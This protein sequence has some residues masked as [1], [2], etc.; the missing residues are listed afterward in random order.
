M[1]LKRLKP[2]SLILMKIL[3]S[4]TSGHPSRTSRALSFPLIYL[5]KKGSPR[6]ASTLCWRRARLARIPIN[7]NMRAQNGWMDRTQQR[8]Q[9]AFESFRTVGSV[10]TVGYFKKL[11]PAQ[12]KTVW[13]ALTSPNF[14]AAATLGKWRSLCRASFLPKSQPKGS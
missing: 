11:M 5:T 2:T 1:Y 6:I 14:G 3:T 9:S 4:R 8:E 10:F 7:L 12:Q 13:S